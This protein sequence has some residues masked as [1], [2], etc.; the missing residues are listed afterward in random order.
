[1]ESHDPTEFGGSSSNSS[2]FRG[3]KLS[4]CGVVGG[5]RVGW[6]VG[7]LVGWSVGWL[8]GWLVGWR[9]L[10]CVKRLN[11]TPVL[12]CHHDFKSSFMGSKTF[13]CPSF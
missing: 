5:G 1:M 2:D 7:W 4:F 13:M 9:L 11:G 3:P 12:G 10:I 8:V 6:L